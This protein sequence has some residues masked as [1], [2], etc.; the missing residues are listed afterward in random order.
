MFLPLLLL[1]L[2]TGGLCASLT[3]F[4]MTDMCIRASSYMLLSRIKLDFFPESGYTLE[5]DRCRDLCLEYIFRAV[6]A[7]IMVLLTHP[8]NEILRYDLIFRHHDS[9]IGLLGHI[10]QMAGRRLFRLASFSYF[11]QD[12]KFFNFT[13]ILLTPS[14]LATLL[15]VDLLHIWIGS[16]S[17]P[18]QILLTLNSTKETNMKVVALLV[19]LVASSIAHPQ[20][21]RQ[22][23]SATISSFSLFDSSG[24]PSF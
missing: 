23:D 22:F 4:Y 3:D 5:L 15:S 9:H 10:P 17:W 21:K 19:T 7:G 14:P 13:C 12:V 6:P 18:S 11:Q 16:T 20:G 1:S 2:N 24:V 8:W